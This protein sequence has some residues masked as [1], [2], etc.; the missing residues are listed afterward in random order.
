MEKNLEKKPTA[1]ACVINHATQVENLY[2]TKNGPAGFAMSGEALNPNW[3]TIR[4]N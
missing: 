3:S 4:P 1:V 2:S